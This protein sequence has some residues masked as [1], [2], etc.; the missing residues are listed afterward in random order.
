MALDM[1]KITWQLCAG[2]AGLVAAMAA[3]S[4]LKRGWRSVRKSDP[5]LNPESRH[6]RLSDAL[7]WTALTG[8]AVG[9]ARLLAARGAAGGWQ[10][11]TGTEP[12]EHP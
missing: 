10:R 7:L 12:P 9:V 8:A 3:R 11:L 4:A 2:G 6:V 1:H 5:P